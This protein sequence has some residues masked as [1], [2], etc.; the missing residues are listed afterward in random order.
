MLV[1]FV[2]AAA[3][4]GGCGGEQRENSGHGQMN[5]TNP[6]EA[7]FA[8]GCFWGSEAAFRGV[9]GVIDAKVGFMGGTV[10]N[11]TYKQVCRTNTGHAE[12][13]RVVFD[14]SVVSY[15]QLLDIFWSR[16]NPTTLNR[17]GPDVG[18]Q[19]RSA[20]FYYNASQQKLAEVSRDA[21]QNSGKF[22]ERIVTEIT[23]AGEFYLADEHHQRYFEKHGG[24]CNTGISKD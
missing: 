10:V 20:I 5:E 8:M 9:Q 14:S 2:V 3:L 11:P 15:E 13:V 6:Q 1:G 7:V 19:Y 21:M 24:A 23:D 16:H 18:S 22:S 4:I 17:Q 12:V